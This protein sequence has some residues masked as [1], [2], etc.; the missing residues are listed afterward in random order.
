VIIRAGEGF[1]LDTDNIIERVR[2]NETVKGNIKRA[3]EAR[4][5]IYI[6]YFAYYEAKRGMMDAQATKQLRLFNELLEYC[7]IGEATGEV[8]EMAISIYLELK[9]KGKLTSDE[10]DI[11]IAAFCKVNGLIL[12]THNKRHYEHISG[13]SIVD[14]TLEQ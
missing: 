13:L 11:Y 5:R 14:W 3:R 12:V 8:F 7:P 9:A 2:G 1:A 10:N 4:A 6:P